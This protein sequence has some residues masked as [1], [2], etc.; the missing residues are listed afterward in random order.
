[1]SRPASRKAPPGRA[2]A[3]WPVTLDLPAGS[4]WLRFVQRQHPDALATGPGLSRFSDPRTD[5]GRTPRWL[6]LYLGDNF[7]TCLQETILRDAAN[8]A[9]PGPFLV[10]EG[11]LLDWHCAEI[12]VVQPLR[13]IDLRGDA[14]ARG[15]I[16]TDVVN[17]A[18][19]RLARSWAAAFFDH[20]AQFHGAVYRSRF[21]TGDNLVLFQPRAGGALRLVSRLSLLERPRDLA[22]AC[23]ALDLAIVRRPEPRR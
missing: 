12:E 10:A 2:D 23:D 21:Q 20:P 16:P 1:M 11:E 5:R 13:M 9:P 17:A 4:R 15:R 14:L 6:P 3:L 8:A 22:R 19:Q 18:D 7:L